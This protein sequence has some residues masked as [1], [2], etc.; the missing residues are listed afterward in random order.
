M[1]A[2]SNF[3]F[4][5]E[6]SP[7]LSDLGATAERLYAFDPA[8][9]VPRLRPPIGRAALDSIKSATTS[10][11]AVYQ[12]SLLSLQLDWP[13]GEEQTEITRPVETL[14]ACADGL[15]ATRRGRRAS[16]LAPGPR[17]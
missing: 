5:S 16:T 7:L 12:K 6:H 3:G 13:S 4:L 11:A 1:G 17:T 2:R 9:C 15:E 8:S 14:F 10:V